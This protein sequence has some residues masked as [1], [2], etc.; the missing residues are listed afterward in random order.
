MAQT[1]LSLGRNAVVLVLLAV[2]ELVSIEVV[3]VVVVDAV[4]ELH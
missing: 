4:V 2:V 1:Y 3:V